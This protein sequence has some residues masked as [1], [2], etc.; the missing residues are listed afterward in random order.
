MDAKAV[1]APRMGNQQALHDAAD[2]SFVRAEQEVKMI[3][4]RR[5]PYS[6]KG[7]RSFTSARAWS[8]ARQSSSPANAG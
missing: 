8:N 3:A 2:G 7:L 6:A 1:V 4:M 5:Q